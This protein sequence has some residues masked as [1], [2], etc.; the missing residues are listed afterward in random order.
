MDPHSRRAGLPVAASSQ[1]AGLGSM[2]PVSR[3]RLID[4]SL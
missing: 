2:P 1:A 3:P 4:I